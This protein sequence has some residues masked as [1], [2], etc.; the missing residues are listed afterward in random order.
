VKKLLKEDEA[1]ELLGL[2]AQT[3]RNDR[4]RFKRIPFV[5]VGRR[6]VRYRMEDIEAIIDQGRSAPEI[7]THGCLVVSYA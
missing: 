6:A 1:A 5:K 2:S 4:C 7:A 3:L